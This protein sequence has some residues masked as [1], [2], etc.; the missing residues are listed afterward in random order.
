[1]KSIFDKLNLRPGERRLV[2]IVMLVVF[3][4]LN[5]I[6]VWPHFSDWG[7]IKARRTIAENLLRQYQREIGNTRTYQAQLKDLEK[8]GATVQTEAQALSLS[9][10][11]QNQAALSGVQ[12]NRYDPVR[13]TALTVGG[14]TNQFFEEQS[15]IINVTTEEKSL[16]DFLYNLGIGSSLIRVRNFTLNPDPPRHKLQGNVTL[17]ASYQKKAPTKIAPAAA[18]TPPPA[19][20]STNPPGRSTSPFAATNAVAKPKAAVAATATKTNQ[21]ALDRMKGWFK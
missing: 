14:K 3:V 13:Q 12:V 6:F 16:V 9:T 19:A 20:R 1:M 11:V 5:F 7:K 8:Q 17:V 15:G 21:S 4:V 2:I 18:A 10:T